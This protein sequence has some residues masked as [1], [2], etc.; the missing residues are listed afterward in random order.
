M[1]AIIMGHGYVGKAMEEF[2]QNHFEIGIYDPAQ[3]FG[4]T[5]NFSMSS[6][7]FI[8]VPTN[9]VE[10]TGRLDLTAVNECIR[11]LVEWKYV[12]LVVIKSTLPLGT[13]QKLIDDHRV[14]NLRIVFSPEF[15]VE[16]K[17]YN[18]RMRKVVEEPFAIYGGEPE[19][20]QAVIDLLLPIVGGDQ[21][22]YQCEA[23]EAEMV[24]LMSN[25]WL[26]VKIGFQNEMRALCEKNQVNYHEVRNI[27]RADERVM[28]QLGVAFDKSRG[29]GGKC[30]PKDLSELISLSTEFGVDTPI[31]KGAKDWELK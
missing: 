1:K 22:V 11:K 19:D 23:N 20:T 4:E 15:V 24:K 13:T 9:L 26:A 31:L 25:S 27:W 3:G 6:V 16:S 17:H 8:C 5:P 14:H 21:R 29:F 10:T 7:V 30:L 12:G 2:L 18:P 28:N